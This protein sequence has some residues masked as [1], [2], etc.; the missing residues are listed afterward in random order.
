MLFLPADINT[1]TAEPSRGVK[2]RLPAE[3]RVLPHWCVCVWK[4]PRCLTAWL[5]RAGRLFMAA[6]LTTEGFYLHV[7]S[8]SVCVLINAKTHPHWH[9]F[10]SLGW[11]RTL[12]L[13]PP[14]SCL[15]IFRVAS[16]LLP[17]LPCLTCSRFS[18]AQ[19]LNI[20]YP[21]FLTLLWFVLTS[22]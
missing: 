12:T 8:S 15:F 2:P 5:H 16:S 19:S 3:R 10:L 7:L 6:I 11:C 21:L 13:Q 20:Q 22:R 4:H 9:V 1:I 18:L 14:K 17:W